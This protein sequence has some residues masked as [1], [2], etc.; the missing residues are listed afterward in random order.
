MDRELTRYRN[1]A[2]IFLLALIVGMLGTF[3]IAEHVGENQR[4]TDQE[5]R[6]C[7]MSAVAQGASLD[8]AQLMCRGY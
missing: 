4:I 1:I 5:R 3:G 2:V 8:R 7:Q 6:T